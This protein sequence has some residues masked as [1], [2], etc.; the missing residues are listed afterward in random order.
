MTTLVV[1]FLSDEHA[2]PV[3]KEAIAFG[4]RVAVGGENALATG[5]RADQHE[6]ARLGQV[7]VSEQRGYHA[8]TKAGRDEY[9]GLAAVGDKCGAAGLQCAMFKRPNHRGADG[10]DAAAVAKC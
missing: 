7:E 6:Q 3:A 8:K 4:N 1:R 2:V 5:K 9:L 10:E